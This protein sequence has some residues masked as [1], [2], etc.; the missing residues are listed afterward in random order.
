MAASATRGDIFPSQNVVQILVGSWC[1]VELKCQ[2]KEAFS[3]TILGV[4]LNEPYFRLVH[5]DYVN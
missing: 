5:N 4:F 1:T 2:I 3:P